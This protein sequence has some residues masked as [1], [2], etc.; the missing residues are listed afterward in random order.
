MREELGRTVS[1]LSLELYK[2]EYR[3]G[4]EEDVRRRQTRSLMQGRHPIEE[5]TTPEGLE[6][7][8]M[9]LT[10]M[11]NHYEDLAQWLKWATDPQTEEGNKKFKLQ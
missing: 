9:R 2:A 10:Y 1:E 8:E 5:I 7:F 11:Q 3:V 6:D 4:T